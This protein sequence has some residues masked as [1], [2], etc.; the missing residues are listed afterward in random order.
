MPQTAVVCASFDW[1]LRRCWV[2]AAGTLPYSFA[3]IAFD[4]ALGQ[5]CVGST[6]CALSL[7]FCHFCNGKPEPEVWHRTISKLNKDCR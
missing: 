4:P 6:E 7:T 2:A 1:L 5:R 3:Q